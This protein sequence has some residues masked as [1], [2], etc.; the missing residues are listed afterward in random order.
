M[1]IDKWWISHGMNLQDVQLSLGI[2]CGWN[3]SL[4]VKNF[5]L[6][7]NFL[8]WKKRNPPWSYNIHDR[9]CEN[10]NT[11]MTQKT[12][13]HV[14]RNKISANEIS[15]SLFMTFFYDSTFISAFCRK[16]ENW[17]CFSFSFWWSW[18]LNAKYLGNFSGK[19]KRRKVKFI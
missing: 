9:H 16:Y 8:L 5:S 1:T 6:K 12:D 7:Q 10:L 3:K 15:M 19:N 2:Q 11:A 18:K 4:A 14:K 13:F 17:G